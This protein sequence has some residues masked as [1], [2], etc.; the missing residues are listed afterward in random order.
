MLST[1]CTRV[2]A[3][4][5]SPMRLHRVN[6]HKHPVIV[7]PSAT[8]CACNQAKQHHLP[9]GG[10]L[11]CHQEVAYQEHA[12]V[13]PADTLQR[14]LQCCLSGLECPWCCRRYFPRP[15]M[16][17][18]RSGQHGRP[19]CQSGWSRSIFKHPSGTSAGHAK[20]CSGIST[21]LE[22]CKQKGFMLTLIVVS[23]SQML[24]CSSSFT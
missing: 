7:N 5:V 13:L 2:P 17:D 20:M 14:L 23:P 10:R 18:V 22:V 6:S 12:S 19:R 3:R 15:F 11:I 8:F 24:V 4:T 16:T 1:T 21:G 9:C